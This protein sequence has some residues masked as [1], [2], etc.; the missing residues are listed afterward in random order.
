MSTPLIIAGAG[1]H[2]RELLTV[3]RAAN[4][5]GAA[6]YDFL[7]FVDDGEPDLGRLHRIGAVLLGGFAWVLTAPA[8]TAFLV[9]VGQPNLRRAAAYQLC[10]AG[11]VPGSCRHPSAVIGADVVLG[12]GAVIGAH[13]SI[14]TNV[15]AGEHCHVNVNVT[16]GHDTWLGDRVTL[17][18]GVNIAGNVILEDDVTMGI[19]SCI[20]Q[21]VRVGAGATVGAGAVVVRDVPPGVI[22]KGVP[23]R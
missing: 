10:Q 14:T 23:A 12:P 11:L 16:I 8:D 13:T 7:G 21:G 20:I 4:E 17:T 5:V 15:R 18:P 6:D 2:G 9:G 1:G 22:V 19:G 3:V